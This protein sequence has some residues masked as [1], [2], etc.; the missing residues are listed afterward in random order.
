MSE[1]DMRDGLRGAVA[2]EPPLVFDPDEL[3]ATARRQ[4]ARRRALVSVG[5]ATMLV[6]VAAVAVPLALG[7]PRGHDGVAVGGPPVTSVTTTTTPTMP[8]PEDIEWPR[9]GVEPAHYTAA[10]L[11]QRG[12]RMQAH[13]SA[14]FAL[15]VPEA[16]DVEVRPFGGESEGSVADGRTYLNAFTRFT[17]RG[18]SYAVDIQAIAPGAARS[19][20]EQCGE[21]GACEV[22]E[23]PDGSWLLITD[24]SQDQARITSVIH[25]RDSGAVVRATGY[26]YDPTSRTAVRYAPAIPVTVEQL[27]ALATDP[28]LHL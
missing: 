27:T 16:T 5:V 26:N 22:Q 1:E 13:L 15:V 17:V 18:T 28:G 2:A 24:D 12:K 4:A 8:G 23:L 21:P 10:E 25:Y 3:M 14:T 11:V 20:E 9:P 19:P 6:A 7:I